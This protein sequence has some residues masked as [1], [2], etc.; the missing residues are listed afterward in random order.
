MPMTALKLAAIMSVYRNDSEGG[1]VKINII[2][3]MCY[4]YV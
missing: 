1:F 4:N 3:P 2:Q